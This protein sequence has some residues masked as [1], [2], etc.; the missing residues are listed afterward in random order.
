MEITRRCLECY[1]SA[2]ELNPSSKQ[3]I[4]GQASHLCLAAPPSAQLFAAAHGM[5]T[6][7]F[8]PLVNAETV[9]CG[10]FQPQQPKLVS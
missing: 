4:K 6:V 3:I 1:Y 2:Y 10:S 5:V 8:Y 9:S 7:A